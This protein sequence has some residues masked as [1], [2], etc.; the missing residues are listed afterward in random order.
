MNSS[1]PRV[2]QTYDNLPMELRE[3][4][5]LAYPDGFSKHLID[6][7]INSGTYVTALPFE[8]DEKIYLIRMPKGIVKEIIDDDEDYDGDGH[9]KDNL[10]YNEKYGDDDDFLDGEDQ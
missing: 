1:K 3:K 6:F 9:L 8:T 10:N 5:K 7:K 4:L 2:I